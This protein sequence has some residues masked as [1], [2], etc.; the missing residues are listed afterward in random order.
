MYT[1]NTV[2]DLIR[3]ALMPITA[4]RHPLWTPAAEEILLMIAAHES[5]MG[6][7]LKQI[8][9]GPALGICQVEPAT[10]YDNYA[11]FLDMRPGLYEQINAISG[12]KG[13]NL[14][15]LEKNSIYNL[16]HA[17]LKLYRS[18]G[19]LPP[20]HD[21]PAMARYCKDHYNGPGAATAED[22][23]L[24]YHRLVLAA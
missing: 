5:G 1:T 24:D 23:M 6:R 22:Y 14:N 8:G 21:I 9:G 16:I 7:D 12:V 10:M 3:R 15:Q 19:N 20:A 4:A 13:P 2:R 11:N 18:K 17:R